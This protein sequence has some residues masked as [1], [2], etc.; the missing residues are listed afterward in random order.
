M[1]ILLAGDSPALQRAVAE[2]L[3]DEPEL[4][5]VDHVYT[6]G[7]LFRALRTHQP[8]I[9]LIDDTLRPDAAP[10][11]YEYL[12][13]LSKNTRLIPIKQ[14]YEETGTGDTQ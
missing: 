14:C 2:L 6:E 5:I 3:T 8:D 4:L 1:R 12:Q 9:L 11:W 7:E 10:A 13:V